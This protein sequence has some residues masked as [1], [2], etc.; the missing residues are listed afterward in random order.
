MHRHVQDTVLML[1]EGNFPHPRCVR[2][3]MQVPRQALNG[4]H[5]GTAQCAK[6]A[7]RKRQRLAE[8]ETIENLERAFRAYGQPM[9]AVTDFRYLGRLLTAT[10][11]NWPA[12]AGN[13]QKAQRIWGRLAK[14]LG[15]EGAK[16][17]VSLTF[18]IAVTQQVLLFGAETWVLTA[19]T[20]K[21]LDAFQGRVERKLTG[22]Q[23]RR[24]R[25]GRWYYPSLV[26]AMKEAGIVRIRTSILRR[27][28]TVAQFIA[29]RPIL[30]LC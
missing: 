18:Y 4:R 11:N 1:E 22:R 6:G 30:D 13:I 14:I 26:G 25:N 28:N 29:T 9:E 21:A 16:P 3:D 5:L 12:V 23:S 17:K 2:C 19:K 27:Q 8:T 15:R 10:D 24:G 20:E 7:E